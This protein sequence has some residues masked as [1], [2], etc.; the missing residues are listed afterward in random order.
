MHDEALARAGEQAQVGDIEGY[1]T[2]GEATVDG[3]VRLHYV[4]AGQGPL[5]VLLHGFPE[6][7]YGW[8]RQIPALAQAGF[9]VV[10]PDMRGYN[11][12]DKPRGWRQYDTDRLARDIAGLIAHFGVERAHV[13]GHDWGAV[14]AYT[15]AMR[16]PEA[17]ER[18]AILNV[19]HPQRM[20]G[21]MRSAG[22]LRKSWYMVFFQLP[23]LP[24]RLLARD[25]FSFAKRSLRAGSRGSFSDADLERY[26]EAWS[27][28]GALTAMI[29]YY[30]ALLR[31]S[32]RRA[33]ASLR[34][35][36][37]PT[38]VIWGERDRYIGAELAEPA[39]QWVPDVRVE[40]LP[41]ATHWVQH[42]EP[43]RVNELLIEFFGAARA[44]AGAPP[45]G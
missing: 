1:V 26:A 39:A 15:V 28:P 25:G 18:L 31:R 17:V 5:V 24:E 43:E 45:A 16:H 35:I 11:L 20:L 42:E 29:N 23:W 4:E 12:S 36:G 33:R 30:R 8:R 34:V 7:W 40:R 10:A 3:G 27:R 14:V 22:Q 9:H 2:H 38:L 32:P 19:P 37:A 41:Q 44:A 21:A 13:V 6:F